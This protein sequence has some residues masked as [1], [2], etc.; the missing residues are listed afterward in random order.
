MGMTRAMRSRWD[1]R[2]VP[3]P[4]SIEALDRGCRCPHYDNHRGRGFP[5]NHEL[6][7]FINEDCPLHAM[8]NNAHPAWDVP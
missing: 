6:V 2:G 3:N 4:G 5:L 8:A 7:F 1:Q